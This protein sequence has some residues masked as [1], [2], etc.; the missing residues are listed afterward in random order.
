M[1]CV[2]RRC[3]GVNSMCESRTITAREHRTALGRLF[4]K[5][6]KTLRFCSKNYIFFKSDTFLANLDVISVTSPR[7]TRHNIV[8]TLSKT[9][10]RAGHGAT[11]GGT[12]L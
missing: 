7:P 9:T 2:K 5:T 6:S 4:T 3:G 12:H 8:I 1:M 11:R 10:A